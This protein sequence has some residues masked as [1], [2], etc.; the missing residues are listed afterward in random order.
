MRKRETNTLKHMQID[1]QTH[2]NICKIRNIHI[3]EHAKWETN[4]WNIFFP[5]ILKETS[6]VHSTR[7]QKSHVNKKYIVNL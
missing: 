2:W 3:E 7:F 4:K 6:I 5:M 1:K